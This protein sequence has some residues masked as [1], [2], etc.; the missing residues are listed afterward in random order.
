MQENDTF[1]CFE[2]TMRL[3]HLDQAQATTM[4]I[5]TAFMLLPTSIT[6]PIWK[7]LCTAQRNHHMPFAANLCFDATDV[8]LLAVVK[9]T[10]LAAKAVH[11]LGGIEV[12][13]LDAAQTPP[14]L[15]DS[16][17]APF[18]LLLM[19]AQGH[20]LMAFFGTAASL[21]LTG[22]ALAHSRRRRVSTTGSFNPIQH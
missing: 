4:S 14:N 7:V 3:P 17:T 13:P 8:A 10:L 18:P 6:G 21:H 22:F 5:H 12:T 2:P 15:I 19:R 11:A 16:I 20:Q 9:P 1:Q